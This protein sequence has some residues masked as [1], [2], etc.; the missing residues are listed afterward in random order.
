MG[1]GGR[2]SSKHRRMDARG[3]SE[4]LWEGYGF[5]RVHFVEGHR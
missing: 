4:V 5:G 3:T 2:R 1:R